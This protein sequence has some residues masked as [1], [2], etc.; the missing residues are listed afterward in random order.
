MLFRLFS[1]KL[2]KLKQYYYERKQCNLPHT[3]WT[4]VDHLGFR[5]RLCLDRY[6][7]REITAGAVWESNSVKL[8]RDLVKPG[9]YIL[10]VGAN[11]GYFTL[12][13][14]RLV[15]PSGRVIAIEP[16]RE[17][18]SRLEWHLRKNHIE[19]VTV[20][21]IGLSDE[22]KDVEIAIGECS[23]TLHWCA[24]N[25]PRLREKVKLMRLDDW[26]DSHS[27]GGHP[28]RLDFLKVDVDGHE[29]QFLVGAERTL[30]RHRPY[31]LIEF[32]QEALF[33]AGY[34]AWDLA[35]QLESLGYILCSEKDGQPF[36]NRR[37]L[38]KEAG[39]FSHSTNVLARPT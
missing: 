29:P 36:R 20:E 4:E 18:M 35:D 8:I 2:V 14:A 34:Y 24:D 22:N 19:N 16:T 13:L 17:Y 38:L 10:D 3:G 26:L 27:A 25:S 37:A 11:F 28:D 6:L 23:A 31:I 15:S 32:C 21:R 30:R 12:L 33:A 1:D 9:M 39:N 7:D 5:W